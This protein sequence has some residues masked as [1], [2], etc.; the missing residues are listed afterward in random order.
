[1]FSRQAPHPTTPLSRRAGPAQTT[2]GPGAP[3]PLPG[4]HSARISHVRLATPA[5]EGSNYPAAWTRP[6]GVRL[7][8]SY[9]TT[10]G[11]ALPVIHPDH[12]LLVRVTAL[13]AS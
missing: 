13:E 9:L 5:Y 10:T 1:M 3:R 7:P 6:G 8:G 2:T 12:M 11:I 4:L